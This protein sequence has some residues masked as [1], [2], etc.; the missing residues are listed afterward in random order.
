LTGWQ[1]IY[2]RWQHTNNPLDEAAIRAIKMLA[3]TTRTRG[4]KAKNLR[5][6]N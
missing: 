3:A 2:N 5:G 1:Y 6:S 4:G